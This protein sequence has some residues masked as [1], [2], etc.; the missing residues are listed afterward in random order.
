MGKG[1]HNDDMWAALSVPTIKEA[2]KQ[3][4]NV[5]INPPGDDKDPS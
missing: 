5:H 4:T 2:N 3:A 1:S